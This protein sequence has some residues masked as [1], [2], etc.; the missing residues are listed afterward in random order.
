MRLRMATGE[1]GSYLKKIKSEISF[2]NVSAEVRS[3]GNS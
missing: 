2:M 3:K 1:I